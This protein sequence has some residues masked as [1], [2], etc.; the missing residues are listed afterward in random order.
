MKATPTTPVLQGIL[1]SINSRASPKTRQIMPPIEIR[2]LVI[3]VRQFK[4]SE[5]T[6]RISAVTSDI[7]LRRFS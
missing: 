5:V 6:E 4:N 7:T 3:A 1:G 2:A